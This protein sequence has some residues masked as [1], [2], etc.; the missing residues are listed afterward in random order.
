SAKFWITIN[1]Y[2]VWA[3]H[4]YLKGYWPP[5]KRNIL[6]FM[7]VRN[8][9]VMSHNVAYRKIKKLN[10][11]LQ[12]GIAHNMIDFQ[13]NQNPLNR[14]VSRFSNFHWNIDFLNKTGE[15]LDFI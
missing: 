2:N 8:N 1:E 10:N 6:K 3:S 7:K 15:L 12:I 11:S 13:S 14:L 4:G 5:F 9:L